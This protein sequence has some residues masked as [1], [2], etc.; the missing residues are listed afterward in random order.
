M[1]PLI[2]AWHEW[3]QRLLELQ[4]AWDYKLI[5][6]REFNPWSGTTGDT[7]FIRD[8]EQARSWFNTLNHEIING[9]PTTGPLLSRSGFD[10]WV[11]Q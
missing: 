6:Y 7:F 11:S 2:T 5:G 10:I 3:R 9:I 8:S 1:H 4:A